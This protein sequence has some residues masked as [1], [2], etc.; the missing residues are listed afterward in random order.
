VGELRDRA[1]Q[2]ANQQQQQQAERQRAEA[3]NVE[4]F[5]QERK[6][7]AEE[8]CFKELGVRVTFNAESWVDGYTDGRRSEVWATIEGVKVTLVGSTL[9]HN[10]AALGAAIQAMDEKNKKEAQL[11][12]R[13]K[14][15]TCPWCGKIATDY[16]WERRGGPETPRDSE[17]S[18]K[19]HQRDCEK[20]PLGLRAVRGIRGYFN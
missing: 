8:L 14:A 12:A 15:R 13:R 7:F 2:A 4:A 6:A 16:G 9:S 5:L 3:A 1:L 20:A 19:Y 10:I 17:L 18:L 11:E